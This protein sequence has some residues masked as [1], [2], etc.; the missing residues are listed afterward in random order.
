LA[1]HQID[2]PLF[3]DMVIKGAA[4]LEKNKKTLDALN[5][6]P[7]PDGDTG[8]NMS[9]TM[10]SAVREIKNLDTSS[11]STMADAVSIGSLKGARGNSGVILSQIF[12]G[13]SKA[14]SGLEQ[15]DASALAEGFKGGME[16]AYKAVLKPKEGTMLTVAK[17][18]AN[19]AI[20]QAASGAN[21]YALMDAVLEEGE[22]ILKKTP[23][24][25]PVLKQAGVVDAGGQGLLVLFTG[26]KM[27]L[28]GEDIADMP[29][30]EIASEVP[31]QTE[32]FDLT[33]Q[34]CTEFLIKNLCDS[35]T[36]PDIDRFREK[37]EKAGDCVLVVGDLD[38]VKVHIHTN[39]PGKALQFALRLGELSSIKI[40]NMK[41]QHR[42]M[43]E[44]ETRPQ[45]TFAMA[46]VAIGDGLVNIFKDLG[47]DEVIQGGQTMNPSTETIANA[48][49]KSPSDTVIVFPNNKNIIMAA[50][51]AAELSKKRVV[52]IP[53]RSIPQGI[54]AAIAFNPEMTLEQNE[55]RMKKAMESVNSGSVT[56][57]VRATTLEGKQIH[58]GDILGLENGQLLHVGKDV[59]AVAN[60]LMKTMV[61]DGESTILIFYGKDVKKEDAEAFALKVSRDHPHCDVEIQYGGQP[62]YFYVFSVE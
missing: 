57:A 50:Q 22:F 37:I 21:I 18:M 49:E 6:F 45:K 7:V 16:A 4:L 9:L 27:A 46:A 26:F 11:I 62:L 59:H 61:K 30:F 39:E 2:G 33:Y 20:D 56:F 42:P 38:L 8:T 1:K 34:Y 17:Y 58:E 52:V 3:K 31:T 15:A 35:I 47:V 13:F 41:E 25:L 28:D 12:R 23:E 32:G 10:M 19:R 54:S 36:L 29:V 48:I 53:T 60:D 14:L 44:V 43:E 5:V 51:Q 55:A 40:D 24:M